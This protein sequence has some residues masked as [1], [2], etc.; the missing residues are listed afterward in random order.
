M[1]D[2]DDDHLDD[3][4]DDDGDDDHLDDHDDSDEMMHSLRLEQGG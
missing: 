4:D 3:H 2:G 1:L